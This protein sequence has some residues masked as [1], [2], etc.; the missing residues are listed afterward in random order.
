MFL[1]VCKQTFHISKVRIFQKVKGVIIR[2]LRDTVFYRKN[3]V[4]KKPMA[5]L[6]YSFILWMFL[7]FLNK[8][9]FQNSKIP[10]EAYFLLKAVKKF[11]SNNK[12][13]E[14][15]APTIRSSHPEVFLRK[16]VL[17]TRSKFTGEHPCEVWFQ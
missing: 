14:Y 15:L 5:F 1:Y 4:L 8:W 11:W 2:N 16:A 6:V 3:N 9:N 7:V 12:N 17:K 13:T 10:L